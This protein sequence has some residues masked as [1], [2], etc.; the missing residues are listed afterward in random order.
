[1]TMSLYDAYAMANDPIFLQRIRAAV[2]T[3]AVQ[4][5]AEDPGTANNTNRQILSY[6]VLN[7][8]DDTYARRF[9]WALTSNN[10]VTT[11]YAGN[12]MNVPDADITFS[13][14]SL[15]DAMAKNGS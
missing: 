14:N 8:D 11:E 9:A 3:A 1:M 2:I 6:A 13:V 5:A 10:T 15:W 12:Q 7:S 4:V